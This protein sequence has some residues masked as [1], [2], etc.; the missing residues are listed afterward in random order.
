MQQE[1]EAKKR[2]KRAPVD[3]HIEDMEEK[4]R[5][6]NSNDEEN[7]ENFLCEPHDGKGAAVR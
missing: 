7:N 1:I 5:N 3:D 4:E 6:E 2:Q